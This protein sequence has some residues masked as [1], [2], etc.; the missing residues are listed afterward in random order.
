MNGEKTPTT[1]LLN[2]AGIWGFI[3]RVTGKFLV[4]ERRAS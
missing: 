4:L 2:S 3:L 1:V